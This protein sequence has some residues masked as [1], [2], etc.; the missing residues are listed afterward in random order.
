MKGVSVNERQ[1]N[2][3]RMN[4]FSEKSIALLVADTIRLSRDGSRRGRPSHGAAFS[5]ELSRIMHLDS[6][7]LFPLPFPA[8]QPASA[9]AGRRKDIDA[10]PDFGRRAAL[11]MLV[12]SEV[13]V[14]AARVGQG[15]IQRPGVLDGVLEEQT[16]DG[17]DEAFDAAVLP[18]TAGIAVL[19]ANP[20]TPQGQAKQLRREHR[21]VVGT[22]E[23]RTA[24]VAAGRDEVAPDSQRRLIRYS[25][26]AQTGATRMIHD[27]QHDVL[28]TDSIRLHQQIH[29]PDQVTG[30][31]ARDAMLQRS[32]YTQDGVVLSSDRVR[33]V[34]F[35]H[36]HV[37][38]LGEAAVE[39][40]GNRPTSRF[41][42][43]GFE[44]N[45]FVSDPARF[46]RRMGISLSCNSAP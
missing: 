23:S 37:P 12:G 27:G 40:V 6:R 29:A 24:V 36:R 14:G 30:N 3:A 2:V 20:H 1:S 42:H 7:G 39:A 17:P 44:A 22:Q 46:G 28:P 19:Q 33:D 41:R 45:E 38:P 4:K 9:P 15:P 25:L 18:G 34:R 11:E 31:G 16:F 43:E 26:H 5:V 13:I 8:A 10:G 32:T 35:A 21:F